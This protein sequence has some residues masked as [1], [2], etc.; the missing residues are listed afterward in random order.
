MADTVAVMNKGEIEQMGAPEELYELPRTAF[1]ANFLGQ[2]NLFTGPVVGVDRRH[3]RASTSPGSRHRRSRAPGPSARGRRDDRRAA[4]EARCSTRGSG[5]G[6]PASTCSAPAASIDVS[7]SGVSTQYHGRRSPVSAPSTVFAQNMVFGPVV[8][9][10]AEVWVSWT[11]RPRLRPRGRARRRCRGSPATPTPNSI[12]VQRRERSRAGAR[13]GLAV[14][15]AAFARQRGRARSRRRRRREP[16]RA[17]AAAAG[18]PVPGAVLPDA[19][20][21]AVLTSFQAPCAAATSAS[22]TT[23]LQLAELRRQSIADYWPHIL[24]SFGYALVATVFALLFSYPL[25][26]FIGVKARRWPAAA[27]PAC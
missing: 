18:H 14:A 16:D 24:R 15:F 23:A 7:F 11:R 27:E 20:D 12:A 1:V 26:Y 17:V 3:H 25:A 10:G 8:N 9:V 5:R 22:T 4:G 13:G 19:A 2:S 6:S 21:L